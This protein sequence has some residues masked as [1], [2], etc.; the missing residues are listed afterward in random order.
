MILLAASCSIAILMIVLGLVLIARAGKDINIDRLKIFIAVAAGFILSALFLELLPENIEHFK[1]GPHSFFRWSF[2][3]VVLVASFERFVLPRLHFVNDFFKPDL[4]TLKHIHT[5]DEHVHG[6]HDA[7]DHHERLDQAENC[8]H[9]H[10][11]AHMHAHTHPELLGA[12]QVC[13]AIGCFMICSFF[14]GIT[15]SSVQ[16]VDRKLGIVLII[17]VVLHLLPEG[18][19]SGVM[20]LGGGASLKSAKK[21]L[22]LIG[23]SFVLGSIVP[24]FFTGFETE[25]IAMSS[26]ILMFV[27]LVQLLPTALRLKQAPLWLALGSGI[28]ISSHLIMDALGVGKLG[29]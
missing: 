1:A 22:L 19:L 9:S 4:E 16:A 3:G 2:F 25:F 7:H 6:E 29:F 28:F 26:G 24:L 20:A 12:G 21:V 5:H 13:S 15:L 14:D 27:A 17:G 11:H 23:G 18:V 10:D 8:A